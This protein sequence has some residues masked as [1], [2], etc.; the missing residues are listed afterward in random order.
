MQLD[1]HSV[2]S[3]DIGAV[4]TRQAGSECAAY[5]VRHITIIG[6]DGEVLRIAAFA[7]RPE[8]LEIPPGV[9]VPS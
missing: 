9:E 2:S 4:V 5:S 8:A 3:I 1:I 7:D 6:M